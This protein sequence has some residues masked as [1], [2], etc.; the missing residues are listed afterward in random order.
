MKLITRSDFDGLTCAVLLKEVMELEHVEFAHP[1]DVQD[2]KIP[3]DDQTVLTNL[4]YVPGCGLWFDHHSSETKRVAP[5]TQYKGACKVAPSAARVVYEYYLN[6]Y[7]EQFAKY[8]DLVNV[9]DKSDTADFTPEEVQNPSEW[10][11]LSF[12]MDARTNLG[13]YHD[14]Q[15]SNRQLMHEMVNWIG[16]YPPEEILKFPDVK[17]RVDRY[18]NLKA[19]FETFI[20]EHSYQEEKVVVTDTRGHQVPAGNRFLIHVWY[21]DALIALRVL[22]GKQNEFAVITGGYNIFD[23]SASTDLGDVMGK[24]GG[25]GHRSA[26]TCQPSYED[27]DRVLKELIAAINQIEK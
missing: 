7:R 6:D 20:K 15:I 2:G 4:P 18:N 23:R 16:T 14:Y 3:V 10:I 27:V 22:D 25:G 1:K 8:Q 24:Y 17:E 13:K 26:A 5:K 12:V 9:V 11:L 19:E 21:P